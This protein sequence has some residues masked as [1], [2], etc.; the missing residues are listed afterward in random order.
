MLLV[1]VGVLDPSKA[2]NHRD[3]GISVLY[4]AAFFLQVILGP[5][6]YST[7]TLALLS[8][9]GRSFTKSVNYTDKLFM[10][11]YPGQWSRGAYFN[12]KSQF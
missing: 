6:C 5:S 1:V 8:G 10:M 9:V 3:T 12:H 7:G 11:T 4:Y 2:W